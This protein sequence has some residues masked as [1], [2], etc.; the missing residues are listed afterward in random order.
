[1]HA[2]AV[3]A[4]GMGRTAVFW[5]IGRRQSGMQN[6]HRDMEKAFRGTE[7]PGCLQDTEGVAE[8]GRER[9]GFFGRSAEAV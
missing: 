6:L 8:Y 1:M 9:R 3:L 4:I 2:A 7:G 5:K